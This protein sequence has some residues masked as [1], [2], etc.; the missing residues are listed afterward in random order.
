[1]EGI[2]IPYWLTPIIFFLIGVALRA[3]Y[4][5]LKGKY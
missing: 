3:T 4:D 2:T 5:M 1:M